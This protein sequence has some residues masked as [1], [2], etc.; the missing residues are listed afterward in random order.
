M[1]VFTVKNGAVTKVDGAP[2]LIIR[3][4]DYKNFVANAAYFEA[5][6]PNVIFGCVESTDATYDLSESNKVPG[7]NTDKSKVGVYFGVC[8]KQ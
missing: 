2:A 7:T 5:R 8:E 6:F 4:E 1:F 3:Y